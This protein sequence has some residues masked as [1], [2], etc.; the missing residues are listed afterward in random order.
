MAVR[1]A[2]NMRND[3]QMVIPIQK[4]TNTQPKVEIIKNPGEDNEE[5]DDVTSKVIDSEWTKPVTVG[6]GTYSIIL[7]NAGGR[8]S[9]MYNKGDHI[10]CYL[11]NTDGTTVQFWGRID[12][13]KDKIKESGQTLTIEGRHRSWILTETNV[14]FEAD[15]IEPSQLLKNIIDKFT[16]GFTYTNVAATSTTM[17]VRWNYKPFWECVIEICNK[18]GV[19]CYVDDDLDFHLFAENSII[20]EDAFIADNG[21]YIDSANLGTDDAYERTRV[22][23]EGRDNG[24]LPIIYTAISTTETTVREAPAVVDPSLNTLAQV[25]AKAEAELAIYEDRQVQ[26]TIK[27]KGLETL[28]PGD[29]VP[30]IITRQKIFGYYKVLEFTH[31]W[32]H[33][34]PWVTTSVIEEEITETLNLLQRARKE[35]EIQPANNPEKFLFSF[36]ME[37]NDESQIAS[38]TGVIVQ[39]GWLKLS[40]S[41]GTMTSETQTAPGNINK[42]MLMVTGF[43]VGNTTYKLSAN[44]GASSINISVGIPVAIP[45]GQQSNKLQLEIDS[46]QSDANNVNP[47]IDDIAVMYNIA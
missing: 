38:K 5:T 24:G 25:K 7:S 1:R 22:T 16:T 43:A 47:Q 41:P 45:A 8:I 12:Y 14:N 46:M 32:G 44:G 21:N 20:N 35:N 26:A 11:D 10:K 23:V 42:V 37:F 13:P 36:N 34:S 28:A 18:A 6:I 19:D 30:V 39:D 17:S 40:T 33:K 9:D 27:S 2:G 15:D 29:N 31:R 3:L 4:V